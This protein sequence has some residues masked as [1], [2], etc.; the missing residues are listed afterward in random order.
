MVHMI[1][2]QEAKAKPKRVKARAVKPVKVDKS[3]LDDSEPAAPPP[4]EVPADVLTVGGRSAPPEGT[5]ITDGKRVTVQVLVGIDAT[6]LKWL[7]RERVRR[8]LRSRT[9]TLR[10]IFAEARS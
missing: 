10:K 6:D 5:V 8:G 4:I 9:E 1:K 3:Q 7:E 2:A